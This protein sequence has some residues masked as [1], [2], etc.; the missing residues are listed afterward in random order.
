MNDLTLRIR[1]RDDLTQL[2]KEGGSGW[3]KIG[4]YRE[5]N[6]KKIE[7]YNWD[8]SI[9]LKGDYHPETIKRREDNRFFVGLKNAKIET[10]NPPLKWESRNPI[11][12]IEDNPSDTKTLKVKIDNE[13]IDKNIDELIQEFEQKKLKPIAQ[14]K[15]PVPSPQKKVEK[16]LLSRRELIESLIKE[17]YQQP[18]NLLDYQYN[19]SFIKGWFMEKRRQWF[20]EFELDLEK[21]NLGYRPTQ[22]IRDMSDD[23]LLEVYPNLEKKETQLIFH[24]IRLTYQ[25]S[26]EVYLL[27]EDEFKENEDEYGFYPHSECFPLILYYNPKFKMIG[28]FYTFKNDHK[29]SSLSEQIILDDND[30]SA[31]VFDDTYQAVNYMIKRMEY[32]LIES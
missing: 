29:I 14:T 15:K 23:V 16:K 9:V 32:Y 27:L 7:V 18:I 12:Y 26:G 30:E 1:T 5:P 10:V 4:A 17:N 8:G 28:G 31:T 19:K 20:F 2:L 11:R 25:F 13:L 24:L 6:I 21:Q 22:F 3:W